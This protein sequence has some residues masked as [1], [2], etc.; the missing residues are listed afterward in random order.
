MSEKL[1][2]VHIRRLLKEELSSADKKEIDKLIKK[3]IERDRAEQ[4]RIMK[5]EIEAE[6]KTSLGKSFFGNPGKVR[7]AIEEI[8]REELSREM[9]PGSDMEKSVVEITKKVLASW[10]EMLYKQQNIINRI[11]IK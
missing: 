6:L 7:K 1:L 10:H 2:R 9:R 4:K 11:R 8:A 5:K 3:G